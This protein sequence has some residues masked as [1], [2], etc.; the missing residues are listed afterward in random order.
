MWISATSPASHLFFNCAKILPLW[1]E[2]M[3]WLNSVGVSPD[4]PRAHFLQ[5]SYCIV[6]DINIQRWQTWWISLT[7]CIWHHRN[8]IIFSND[9]F[10]AYKLMGGALLLCWTWFKNLEKGFHTRFHSWSSNIREGFC[11]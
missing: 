11:V 1:W 2:S 3:S 4:T 5:H 7:W 8:R 9:S 6:E 10:N